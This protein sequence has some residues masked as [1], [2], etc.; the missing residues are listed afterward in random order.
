LDRSDSDVARR[1]EGPWGGPESKPR[2]SQGNERMTN[3]ELRFLTFHPSF[4]SAVLVPLT[5]M[6]ILSSHPAMAAGTPAAMSKLFPENNLEPYHRFA[7][8]F[9]S[10]PH[11]VNEIPP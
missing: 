9:Q 4:S 6:A 10:D 8:L 11:L 3:V 1:A 5:K 7:K 2:A